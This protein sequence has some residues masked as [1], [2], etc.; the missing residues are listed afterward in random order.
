MKWNRMK[1]CPK[2]NFHL[3]WKYL[4]FLIS[5]GKYKISPCYFSG[6]LVLPFKLKK[7]YLLKMVQRDTAI[8]FHKKLFISVFARNRFWSSV[9]IL[10]S[11]IYL[12]YL[13]ILIDFKI[14]LLENMNFF[15]SRLILIICIAVEVIIKLLD[16]FR[17]VKL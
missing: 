16:C 11:L 14:R 3:E 13:T 2:I 4:P 12:I 10:P 8:L 15:L 6:K 7:K 5:L 1:V 9:L 17:Y